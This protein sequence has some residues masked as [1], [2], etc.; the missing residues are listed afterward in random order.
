MELILL[1]DDAALLLSK[2]TLAGPNCTKAPMVCQLLASW[3][4][5]TAPCSASDCMP[6]LQPNVTDCSAVGGSLPYCRWSFIGCSQGRVSQLVLGKVHVLGI[7]SWLH[8]R[9]TWRLPAGNL[10][11]AAHPAAMFKQDTPLV[12]TAVISIAHISAVAPAGVMLTTALTCACTQ[13][14]GPRAYPA[15]RWKQC[16]PSWPRWRS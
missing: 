5:Y 16:L 10:A 2:R 4:P 8:S 9:V 12:S 6:C 3:Q 15:C 1:Q 11:A 13:I 7:I 14:G